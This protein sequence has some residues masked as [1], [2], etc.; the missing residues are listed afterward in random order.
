MVLWT[1][2]AGGCLW[3]LVSCCWGAA[4]NSSTPEEQ[5]HKVM[6]VVANHCSSR[7]SPACLQFELLSQLEQMMPGPKVQILSGV[8]LSRSNI[9]LASLPLLSELTDP[10]GRSLDATT[11]FLN[12]LLAERLISQLETW[13]VSVFVFSN[14]TLNQLRSVLNPSATGA[15]NEKEVETGRR[16]RYWKYMGSALV[17]VGFSVIS[18]LISKSLTMS[19]VALAATMLLGSRGESGYGSHGGYSAPVHHLP[20][21]RSPPPVRNNP[22]EVQYVDEL[23]E[24]SRVDQSLVYVNRKSY[25]KE[26]TDS[27]Y[28]KLYYKYK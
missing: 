11:R 7:R 10:K 15:K 5:L 3:M 23:P 25:Q 2:L 21:F 16:H 13:S 1:V 17:T 27:G 12:S 14:N 4:I 19:L 20:T 6:E 28:D 9:S 24:D 18:A 8:Y 26:R 22:S